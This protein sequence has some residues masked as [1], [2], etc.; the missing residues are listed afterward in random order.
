MNFLKSILNLVFPTYC[1]QCGKSGTA[2]CTKCLSQ[3]E[4]AG[5]ES[6]EWVFPIYDYRNP[7]IKKA[8]WLLKYKNKKVFA[9]IFAEIMYGRMI[10]EIS[11]FGQF[12]DFKKPILIPIPL[13]RKRMHERGFNQA[14]LICSELIK[15]DLNKNFTLEEKVL[16]KINDKKHQAL[17]EN[18]TER[19]KNIIGSFSIKNT[20]KIEDKNIILIDDVTTT[21]ATLNEARKTL[22]KFGAKKIIA[23]T[24]AH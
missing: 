9:K 19:L 4:G 14:T 18:R 15:L 7:L 11:D 16:V 17:I 20:D 6:A 10:E 5:R 8:I 21:G 13:A 1:I 2:I 24:I 12:N 3:C 23:F 22:R